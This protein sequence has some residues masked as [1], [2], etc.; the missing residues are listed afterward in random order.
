MVEHAFDSVQ[1]AEVGDSMSLRPIWSTYRVLGYS[2]LWIK[3]NYFLSLTS[4]LINVPTNHPMNLISV[5]LILSVSSFGSISYCHFCFSYCHLS[6]GWQPQLLSCPSF[7][8]PYPILKS[9]LVVLLIIY[10]YSYFTLVIT[11][12]I[13]VQGYPDPSKSWGGN[14][15]T[16]NFGDSIHFSCKL[17]K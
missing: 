4:V 7:N 3:T 14:V 1:E 16:G 12:N 13:P 15:K 11:I 5:L 17:P 6:P 9:K 10:K 2:E 8:S